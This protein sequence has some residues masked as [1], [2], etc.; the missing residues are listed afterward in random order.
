MKKLKLN[1][2]TLGI[3]SD[4]Q[5][6]TMKGGNGKTTTLGSCNENTTSNPL[7]STPI[8]TCDLISKLC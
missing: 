3:L 5:M 8:E 2:K 6:K 4:Q 1:K 7:P